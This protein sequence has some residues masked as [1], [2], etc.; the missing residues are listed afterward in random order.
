M[1]PDPATRAVY[2][3]LFGCPAQFA[4]IAEIHPDS[5]GPAGDINVTPLNGRD[6]GMTPD[7]LCAA[8]ASAKHSDFDGEFDMVCQEQH[9]I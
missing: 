7:T 5:Q 3:E 1:S 9:L 6:D 2:E 8:S 4:S